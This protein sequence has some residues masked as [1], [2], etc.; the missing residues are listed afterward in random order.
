MGAPDLFTFDEPTHVYRLGDRVLP[1]VTTI[2]KPVGIDYSAIAPDVLERKRQLGSAVHKAC[3]LDDEDDLDDET[4]P[5]LLAP[6]VAAWRRFKTETR[7]LVL[8]NER[9]LYHPRL[10]YAGT[11]DRLITLL[12]DLWVIDLKTAAD[13]A[14][15]YGIQTAAY[16]EL[17]EAHEPGR[18]EARRGTV[19]L[20]DDG[21][22]KLHE[23]RNPNDL[24]AFRALLTLH[25]WKESTR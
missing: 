14:P 3:E 19:H 20:R 2:I 25:S 12:G 5:E 24:A 11:I 17:V 21:T 7:A 23:Y 8:L 6:Y 16:H 15:S 13:P 4:L 18:G 22:Y 9:R 10:L 1:S